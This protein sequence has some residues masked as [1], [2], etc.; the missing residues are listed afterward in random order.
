MLVLRKA[1]AI[2]SYP[3]GNRC[4]AAFAATASL[5]RCKPIREQKNDRDFLDLSTTCRFRHAGRICPLARNLRRWPGSVFGAQGRI[6][7][8]PRNGRSRIARY[9][10]WALS[11]R[12]RGLRS[13][14]SGPGAVS[15][16]ML[17]AFGTRPSA[18]RTPQA[19]FN[20]APPAPSI[21][22]SAPR[23]RRWSRGNR[24]ASRAGATS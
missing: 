15:I 24:C 16:T 19:K 10:A 13:C 4:R 18:A 21:W 17:T 5:C 11:D 12:G 23:V 8:A 7:S 1:K 6:Q 14:K 22:R 2:R 20:A 9:R 3:R